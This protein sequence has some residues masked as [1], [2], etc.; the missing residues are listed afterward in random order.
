[1]GRGVASVYLIIDD[2]FVPAHFAE[3]T[4]CPLGG[5]LAATIQLDW[6]ERAL[7][8]RIACVELPPFSE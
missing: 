2:P 3:P 7:A 1:M 6:G 4:G 8:V 5:A